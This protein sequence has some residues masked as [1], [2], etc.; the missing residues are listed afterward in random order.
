MLLYQL[1]RLTSAAD[2]TDAYTLLMKV[3]SKEDGCF[4]TH[5]IGSVTIDFENDSV[6]L[7]EAE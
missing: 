2:D 6:I 3:K 1:T 4:Y 7:K 5:E